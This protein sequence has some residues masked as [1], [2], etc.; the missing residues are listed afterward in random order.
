MGFV[1]Y[2][3]HRKL[4]KFVVRLCLTVLKY[5]IVPVPEGTV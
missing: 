2:I 3:E 5:R 1:L 4:H